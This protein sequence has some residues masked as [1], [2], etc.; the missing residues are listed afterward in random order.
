MKNYHVAGILLCAGVI[1]GA[2]VPAKAATLK[3]QFI[4]ANQDRICVY[5]AHSHDYYLNVGFSGH[6]SFNV[7]DNEGN[8]DEK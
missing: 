7:P 4:D 3:E 1:V 5:S 2:A 6:C 8:D